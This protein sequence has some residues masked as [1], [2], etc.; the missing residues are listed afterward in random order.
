MIAAY[1]PILDTRDLEDLALSN[2]PSIAQAASE[3]LARRQAWRT[4]V[5]RTDALFDYS[6]EEPLFV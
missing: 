4:G 1:S 3:E 5:A 6:N 2:D